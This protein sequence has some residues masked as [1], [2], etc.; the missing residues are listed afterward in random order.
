MG[1]MLLDLHLFKILESQFM[2]LYHFV[3]LFQKPRKNMCFMEV[4]QDLKRRFLQMIY[5]IVGSR[6]S[7]GKLATTY[8]ILRVSFSFYYY[9]FV[10][11]LV[12]F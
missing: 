9:F 5:A 10:L 2:F 7:N 8:Y 4:A 3:S 6:G 11:V 1:L 12:L